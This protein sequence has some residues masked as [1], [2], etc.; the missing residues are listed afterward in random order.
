[1]PITT[2]FNTFTKE[3]FKRSPEKNEEGV[4]EEVSEMIDMYNY[5]YTQG[6]HLGKYNFE[7]LGDLYNEIAQHRALLKRTC[8]LLVEEYKKNEKAEET[9]SQLRKL[10]NKV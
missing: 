2:D 5:D 7:T 3:F 4:E 8:Q 6:E 1:M 10:R 9:I